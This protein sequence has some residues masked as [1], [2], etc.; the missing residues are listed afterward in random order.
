MSET[1]PNVLAAREQA[2]RDAYNKRF[3]EAILAGFSHGDATLHA[4]QALALH[5][6]EN[7]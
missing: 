1:S 7:K 2:R 3:R 4:E 6:K 5:D